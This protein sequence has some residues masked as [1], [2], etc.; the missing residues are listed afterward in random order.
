[1][2]RQRVHPGARGGDRRPVRQP[3]VPFDDN[4]RIEQA[5]ARF[6]RRYD[7]GYRRA[8]DKDL[9][10]WLDR[11]LDDIDRRDVEQRFRQI[12]EHAG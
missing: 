7:P 11:S 6:P 5:A 10:D 8:V 4:R 3:D 1:M 12:T 9:G 2:M